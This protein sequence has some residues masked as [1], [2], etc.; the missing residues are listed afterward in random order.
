MTRP[1][2]PHFVR[3]F[4]V[5]L[6]CFLSHT[7]LDELKARHA[8]ELAPHF[9]KD[10]IVYEMKS[11]LSVQADRLWFRIGDKALPYAAALG[12]R[13]VHLMAGLAPAERPGLLWV[14]PA[15]SAPSLPTLPVMPISRRL[16]SRGKGN[17]IE[18]S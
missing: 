14:H 9:A 7:F 4:V 10:W 18:G 12:C 17:S 8:A 13:R 5:L 15:A 16:G 2:A 3:L 1:R 6:P 11:S